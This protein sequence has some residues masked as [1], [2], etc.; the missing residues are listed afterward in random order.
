LHKREGSV[1]GL[2]THKVLIA[3][4]VLLMAS[5]AH[6]QLDSVMLPGIELRGAFQYSANSVPGTSVYKGETRVYTWALQPGVGVFIAGLLELDAEIRFQQSTS[7]V[8]YPGT[9][10]D[11]R[12]TE[13]TITDEI[14]LAL[15]PS[16]NVP[17]T[18]RLWAFASVKVGLDWRGEV[19][20]TSYSWG[21]AD[22]QR[23]GWSPRDVVFPMLQAGVKL[24]VAPQTCLL[25]E[26]QYDRLSELE[27]KT[28]TVGVGLGV[29]L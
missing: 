7:E 26:I 19:R 22:D 21:T 20:E 25:L 2:N 9:P 16:Y 1:A 6:A 24:F 27:R 13:R 8:E 10:W 15:G 11:R 29:L 5:D 12:R 14:F 18:S 28:T 23:M 4:V 3:V 17:L